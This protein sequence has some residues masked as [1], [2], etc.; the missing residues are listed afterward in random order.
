M[1]GKYIFYY[2]NVNYNTWS[3]N[4]SIC[5]TDMHLLAEFMDS[6]SKSRR[7]VVQQK[8]FASQISHIFER[9]GGETFGLI[10]FFVLKVLFVDIFISLGDVCTDFWQ[11]CEELLLAYFFCSL[12]NL[13]M[14][15]D[16]NCIY[17]WSND[18]GI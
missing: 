3:C 6:S 18:I 4:H 14:L 17:H 7:N 11:V 15:Y 5:F 2:M 8:S 10:S 16:G 13:C 12:I 9:N 1:S